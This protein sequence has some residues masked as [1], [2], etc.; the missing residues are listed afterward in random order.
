MKPM[1]DDP[2]IQRIRDA[3]HR[4]SEKN[5]HDPRKVVQYYVELQKKYENRISSQEEMTPPRP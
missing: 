2:T 1:K 5:Q 3:R 4:I